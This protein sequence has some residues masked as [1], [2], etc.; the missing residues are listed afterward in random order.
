MGTRPRYV[1]GNQS[2]FREFLRLRLKFAAAI[3]NST[4]RRLENLLLGSGRELENEIASSFS[5][6]GRPRSVG[7][8]EGKGGR[9][10][11]RKR[12]VELRAFGEAVWVMGA[13]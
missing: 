11:A 5:P 8:R 6:E 2:G 4:W 12:D 7:L 3:G 9:E 1:L 13:R 10:R